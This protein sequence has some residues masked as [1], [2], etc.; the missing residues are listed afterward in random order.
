MSL[1]LSPEHGTLPI[2]V[3]VILAKA[4]NF[5]DS[6][7]LPIRPQNI[8]GEQ[9]T[10]WRNFVRAKAVL[11]VC[12]AILFGGRKMDLGLTIEGDDGFILSPEPIGS[13]LSDLVSRHLMSLRVSCVP[14]NSPTN[15]FQEF[16]GCCFVD[17]C[18]RPNPRRY[19]SKLFSTF[20]LNPIN[21]DQRLAEKLSS[22]EGSLSGVPYLHNLTQAILA[23]VGRVEKDEEARE[24][25]AT[26]VDIP[27]YSE[28][29]LESFLSAFDLSRRQYLTA[30]ARI[31]SMV[32]KRKIDDDVVQSILKD[33]DTGRGETELVD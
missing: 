19:M 9:I 12:L 31:E 33:V 16:C 29:T 22:L 15:W 1:Y 8:S 7:D 26:W 10:S 20:C 5:I 14:L 27:I 3:S 6:F 2:K 18:W 30:V 24:K 32:Q 21:V 4:R 11:C 25:L 13:E 28:D 23:R 17:N